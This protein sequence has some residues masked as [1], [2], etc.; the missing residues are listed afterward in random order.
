MSDKHNPKIFISY[1]WSNSNRVIELAERLMADGIEI[2]VDKWDLKEGQDKYAFMEQS[3][4]DSTINKVLIICDKAYTEKANQREGGVGDET[5]IIS[6]EI[7]GKIKQEKFIPIIFEKDSDGN[8]YCPTFIK[9]RIYIDLSTEDNYETNYETLLRN[10]HNK[11]LYRKPALGTAPE[12]LEDETTD[13]S[14][15]RATI[16]QIR[17]CSNGNETKTIFLIK[18]FTSEFV[19]ALRSFDFTK[20]E[21][22]LKQIEESKPIRDL[23]VDFLEM[24]IYNGFGTDKIIPDFLEQIY[25]S[26]HDASGRSQYTANEFEFFDFFIWEAFI[27][28]TAILLNYE[29]YKELYQI[30]IHTYFLRKDYFWLALEAKNFVFFRKDLEIIEEVCK[31]KSENPNLYTLAGD[32]LIKRERKPLYTKNSIANADIVLYQ[33][34]CVLETK[35]NGYYWFPSLYCYANCP[36]VIWQKLVSKEY[37]KKI[38]PLFGVT[39]IDSLKEKIRNT[40]FGENMR[41]SGFSGCAPEISHSIKIDSIATLN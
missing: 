9:S 41:Y 3:V 37:C 5:V 34:S 7:Y 28:T 17:G 19:K 29:C 26:T 13:L 33:M 21:I 24:I 36:Q 15:I 18:K 14:P 6:P 39:S 12:W 35:N 32:I 2:V 11:P 20:N 1:S 40:K 22:I 31:P 16:K 27:C 23:Y 10:L 30:L 38:M 4:N 8:P 25:N